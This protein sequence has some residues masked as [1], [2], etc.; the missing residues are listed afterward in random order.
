MLHVSQIK[1][2]ANDQWISKPIKNHPFC[3]IWMWICFIYSFRVHS[4]SFRSFATDSAVW[5]ENSSTS[6]HCYAIVSKWN[7]KC[8]C[9]LD[10]D[11]IWFL[12]CVFSLKF[13]TFCISLFIVDCCLSSYDPIKEPLPVKFVVEILTK[14]EIKNRFDIITFTGLLNLKRGENKR[15]LFYS[16]RSLHTPMALFSFCETWNLNQN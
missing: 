9:H 10:F 5:Q 11:F 1:E 12:V 7:E 6:T 8:R 3:S 16:R 4:T 2:I 14:F 13:T 15:H